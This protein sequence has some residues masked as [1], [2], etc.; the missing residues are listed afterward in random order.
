[1]Q[2]RQGDEKE[3]ESF[4]FKLPTAF[5]LCL[6][7]LHKIEVEIEIPPDMY[8]VCVTRSSYLSEKY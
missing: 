8:V 7:P 3:G 1:M 2:H 6:E 5:D 4:E